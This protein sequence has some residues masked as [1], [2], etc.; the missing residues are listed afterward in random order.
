MFD[1]SV[2]LVG[3]CP[4]ALSETLLTLFHTAECPKALRVTLVESVETFQEAS[5]AVVRY[6]AK[7]E[8]RGEYSD[9]FLDLLT[10][11]QVQAGACAFHEAL[12]MAPTDRPYSLLV[13]EDCRF[14]PEWDHGLVA[15]YQTLRA[16][17]VCA[18]AVTPEGQ[19]RPAFSVVK[20]FQGSVPV[21]GVAPIARQ[22][23]P[24]L[25][26]IWATWPLLVHTSDLRH[27]QGC[28]A[29]DVALNMSGPFWTSK[30]P[31]ALREGT[32]GPTIL[33]TFTEHEWALRGLEMR[34]DLILGIDVNHSNVL[35]TILKFGSLGALQWALQM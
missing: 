29:D 2:I 35:E 8:A 27:F 18:A 3:S 7:A 25:K 33:P 6:K 23:G 9:N 12:M 30:T 4:D 19:I 34:K 16:P 17:V 21:V 13:T 24:N 31:V 26:A 10:V 14:Q 11:H 20:S 15:Q 32:Q 22:Q 1:L 5:E 28:S